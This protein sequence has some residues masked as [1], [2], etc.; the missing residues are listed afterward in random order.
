MVVSTKSNSRW[1][2]VVICLH[3]LIAA[4][5][6]KFYYLSEIQLKEREY[7]RRS[8]EVQ[9][10]FDGLRRDGLDIGIP[11]ISSNSYIEVYPVLDSNSDDEV[12]YMKENATLLMLCRNWELTGVLK[13][14]RSLEDR[15]NHKYNYD[16]VFLNEVPFDE[17]FIE[18]T[19]TMASGKTHYGLIPTKD[20]Y[21]P[22]WIDD[23]RFEEALHNLTENNVIYG[24]S[25]SYRN[26]CRFNSGF[27]FRQSILD[28][29][30][31][32]FRVEP[33]VQYLCDF[34]Y[35]PF[36]YMRTRRK[37]YGF[38]ITLYEYEET[39]P[40]LWDTVQEFIQKN[41]DLIDYTKNAYQFIANGEESHDRSKDTYS[42][43]HFWSNFEIAD[44]NFFRSEAYT[45]YFDYLDK[46]GGFYYERWGDAPVHSIAAALLLEA[47]EIHHFEDIG[48]FHNPY[49]TG[50]APH[51]SALLQRCIFDWGEEEMRADLSPG[52]CLQRWWLTGAGKSFMV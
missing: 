50:P 21:M 36:R 24:G 33:N 37:K 8:F 11:K 7:Y 2:F 31:Y 23:T 35:D 40:T 19:T 14:M 49:G 16:W 5:F 27:F 1:L 47:N 30:D 17:E 29:Y 28:N 51:V 4:C 42:L 41:P 34:A 25:R 46:K 9:H 15:F 22:E 38:V 13:S 6:V 12:P 39:I 3:V 48:Y 10:K 32:Y 20:W 45:R 43:C 26:M 52:S 18:A 44:L